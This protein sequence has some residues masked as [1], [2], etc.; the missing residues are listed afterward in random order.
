MTN[1]TFLGAVIK[2]CVFA[3]E[4]LK[5]AFDDSNALDKLFRDLGWDVSSSLSSYGTISGALTSLYNAVNVLPADPTEEDILNLFPLIS[6]LYSAIQGL[7][8]LSAPPPLTGSDATTFISN[9]PIDLSELLIANYLS[10]ELPQLFYYLTAYKIIEKEYVIPTTPTLRKSYIRNKINYTN[11]LHVVKDPVSLIKDVISWNTVNFSFDYLSNLLLNFLASHD[12]T[13]Y[14]NIPQNQDVYNTA[15]S[16]SD[17]V[18]KGVNI[19]LASILVGSDYIPLKVKILESLGSGID[20]GVIVQV[21]IPSGVSLTQHITSDLSLTISLS[22]AIGD[23]AALLIKPSGLQFKFLN[24]PTTSL[25]ENGLNVSLKYAPPTPFQ[26]FGKDNS[27]RLELA[28]TEITLNVLLHGSQLEFILDADLSGLSL[29]L[30]PS[31]SD[32]FISK[33]FGGQQKKIDFPLTV[34]WSSIHGITF[35]NSSTFELQIPVN[36]SIGPIIIH[37]ISVGIKAPSGQDVVKT[38]IG[39]SIYGELGP[40][41]FAIDNIGMALNLHTAGGNV[42]P[43]GID[44]GFKAPNGIGIAIDTNMVTGG[45]YLYIDAAKGI[46]KGAAE[47]VI[48][49]KIAI[50]GV[51]IITTKDPEG[52][53]GYSFLVMATAAFEPSIPVGFG[54][55]ITGL[56]GIVG[57]NR[58]MNPD[59]IRAGVKS[60][61]IKELLFPTDVIANVDKIINNLEGFFPAKQGRYTLGFLMQMQWSE[62]APL[63]TL[64]MALIINLPSPVRIAILGTLSVTLPD[65]DAKTLQLNVVFAGVVDFDKKYLTFDASIIDS[66]ILSITLSGDI[67]ARMFWG[68]QKEMLISAGGFHPAYNPPAFLLLPANMKRM[69]MSLLD[70]DTIKLSLTTYFA[71]TSNTAQFGADVKFDFNAGVHLYGEMAFDILFQFNPFHLT[72][73]VY[74]SLTL[75]VAGHEL[76]GMSTHMTLDGPQPWSVHGS[77]SY[78]ILGGLISGTKNISKTWGNPSITPLLPTVAL[79]PQIITALSDDKNWHIMPSARQQLDVKVK[80]IPAGTLVLLPLGILA[81][82]QKVAPLGMSIQRFGSQKLS[83][84]GLYDI[85]TV[86][87]QGVDVTA[88]LKPIKDNFAPAQYLDMSDSQKLK[89]ASFEYLKSGVQ[90]GLGDDAAWAPNIPPVLTR[91]IHYDTV[92]V[93]KVHR[94]ASPPAAVDSYLVRNFTRGGRVSDNAISRKTVRRNSRPVANAALQQEGFKFATRDALLPVTAATAGL[95]G[96]PVSGVF[97]SRAEAMSFFR[98]QNAITQDALLMVPA[99]F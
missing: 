97:A 50:S 80:S 79:L 78:K 98:A 47:L 59:A 30:D 41:A 32:G 82:S 76:V 45:G 91:T 4:P 64:N 13:S 20:F 63:L 37:D 51:G 86:N 25:P 36:F 94:V 54:F 84:G 67:A 22:T 17:I 85:D 90:V 23:S 62:A 15:F 74:G 10:K 65:E 26:I 48:A 31:D 33:I 96:V 68:E 1:N 52:N 9:L 14:Y 58:D 70:T 11:L 71:I 77:V 57:V 7:G 66:H 72:A 16:N 99:N 3:I 8:V 61:A 39:A 12:I 73:D 24:H 46:Y 34:R 28:N 92:I 69:S 38:T 44:L 56:G 19:S 87:I 40:V 43:F 5:K 75:E 18:G 89:A 60:G 53:S 83:D 35:T 27:T 81:I 88:S 21:D 42:G 95:A 55:A 6:N 2:H 93:D 49:D 29:I